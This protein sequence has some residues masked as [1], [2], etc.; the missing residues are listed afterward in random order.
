MTCLPSRMDAPCQV[1]VEDTGTR[2]CLAEAGCHEHHREHREWQK[3]R[4]AVS[5]GADGHQ[6]RSGIS[7]PPM[8]SSTPLGLVGEWSAESAVRSAGFLCDPLQD[9]DTPAETHS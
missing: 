3:K 1:H 9:G 4:I 6:K 8:S 2:C 5:P 7:T